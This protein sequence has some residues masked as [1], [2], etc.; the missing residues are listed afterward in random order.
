MLHLSFYPTNGGE[1]FGG[2]YF[3]PKK[4]EDVGLSLSQADSL[5]N[6]TTAFPDGTKVELYTILQILSVTIFEKVD[7]FQAL[8]EI[9]II[10]EN[11]QKDN[12]LILFNL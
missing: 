9:S 6:F 2:V 8:T 4:S 11:I 10:D 3:V 1:G 7:I 5:G 12:Q